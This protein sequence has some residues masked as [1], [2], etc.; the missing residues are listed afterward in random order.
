MHTVPVWVNVTHWGRIEIR[1]LRPHSEVAWAALKDRLP[2]RCPLLKCKLYS[3]GFYF[4]CNAYGLGK[5]KR[6]G[7]GKWD[8]SL[9]RSRIITPGGYWRIWSC[10]L[11][12]GSTK[13][14]VNARCEQGEG[15]SVLWRPQHRDSRD[16]AVL[17]TYLWVRRGGSEVAVTPTTD[18]F[19]SG[20]FCCWFCSCRQHTEMYTYQ[21]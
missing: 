5:Q 17:Y 12:I 3:F 19:L 9:Q 20:S 11:G 7:A 4:F 21:T 14:H 6:S 2:N 10:Q 16:V 15:E 13:T 8:P 1:P 18:H